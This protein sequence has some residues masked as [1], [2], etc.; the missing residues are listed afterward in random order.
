MPAAVAAVADTRRPDD[1]QRRHHLE[2]LNVGVFRTDV[3]DV[4]A[5]RRIG[6]IADALDRDER[7][8]SRWR[9]RVYDGRPDAPAGHASAHDHGVHA[10]GV[11]GAERG[12]AET[13]RGRALDP[14]GLVE[15]AADA[16][17]GVGEPVL[18]GH[19]EHRGTLSRADRITPRRFASNGAVLVEFAP[20]SS[21]HLRPGGS[22]P[23]EVIYYI[24]L[25]SPDRPAFPE[26]GANEA[27]RL[28]WDVEQSYDASQHEHAEG[29]EMSA[30]PGAQEQA[31]P[32]APID[33]PSI[34]D[35]VYRQLRRDISRGVYKPGP[36]RI[37]PLAERFGVSA[38]P[39]REA[40]RRL[41]AEGL[42]TLRK[43]QIVINAL[44]E[45]EL[46]E[47]FAIRAE[48]ETFAVREGA[49]RIRR[50]PER[51]AKL[52]A[53]FEAMDRHETDPEKWRAANQEF[54][55]ELYRAAAMPRLESMIDGLFVACEPYMRLYASTAR[56]FRAGQAQH[57]LILDQLQ[58]GQVASAIAVLRE[59]LSATEEAV[60][61][62]VRRTDGPDGKGSAED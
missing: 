14:N 62:G 8:E 15:V 2:R 11:E 61:A 32:P 13:R 51:V 52:E 43:N 35:V 26:P 1:E 44:S 54:H 21:F 53:L 9:P 50:D 31:I 5:M 19:D 36:I 60:A 18:E 42:V 20:G 4:R 45:S 25:V 57:R 30:Q 12:R 17:G 16:A 58:A 29:E 48:L 38:T 40:L 22:F 39:I 49:D 28:S 59:H 10:D 47:V 41:E 7:A 56:S 55:I 3:E 34:P 27:E 6:P 23:T 33:L 24:Q 37:R 46:R